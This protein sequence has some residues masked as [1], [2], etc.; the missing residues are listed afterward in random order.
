MEFLVL[1]Q[2]VNNSKS[3]TNI[4][5]QFLSSEDKNSMGRGVVGE[6]ITDKKHWRIIGLKLER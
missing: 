4:A 3:W 6:N 2:N 1:K 5:L